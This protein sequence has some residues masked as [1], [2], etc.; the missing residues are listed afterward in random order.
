[1]EFIYDDVDNNIRDNTFHTF[2][3]LSSHPWYI[4]IIFFCSLHA[5]HI[6]GIACFTPNLGMPMTIFWFCNFLKMM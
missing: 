5:S 6:L 3:P 2:T 1:M 4:H